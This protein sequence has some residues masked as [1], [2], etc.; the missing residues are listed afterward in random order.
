MHSVRRK[1]MVFIDCKF[2]VRVT[3]FPHHSQDRNGQA[4]A[5]SLVA[6]HFAKTPN[7]HH[8][9][10]LSRRAWWHNPVSSRRTRSNG[11]RISAC[12]GARLAACRGSA[13]H[14]CRLSCLSCSAPG[15]ATLHLRFNATAE[16]C[17]TQPS[18]PAHGH[19]CHACLLTPFALGCLGCLSVIFMDQEPGHWRVHADRSL[20]GPA[21]APCCCHHCNC[22]HAA[23]AAAAAQRRRQC[24]ALRTARTGPPGAS[25]AREQRKSPQVNC[26]SM[27]I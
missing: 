7:V 8:V 17:R 10:P 24:G 6:S 1:Q 18:Q 20:Y 16:P 26:E 13:Y 4:L 21:C 11:D 23:G 12:A 19:A 15:R 2:K 3:L 14:A 25:L 22:C 9:G 27:Y 5:V